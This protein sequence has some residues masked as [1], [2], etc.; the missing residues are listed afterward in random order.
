MNK[1]TTSLC[2]NP[3]LINNGKVENILFYNDS[4]I[5]AQTNRGWIGSNRIDVLEFNDLEFSKRNK[6]NLERKEH[7]FIKSPKQSSY[8][9]ST[10]YDIYIYIPST[11]MKLQPLGELEAIKTDTQI[12]F[13][14]FY[15]LT[16]TFNDG[17]SFSKDTHETRKFM[18][19]YYTRFELTDLGKQI[20]E[21]KELT[22]LD[23]IDCE[24]IVK[25]KAD[26][27]KVLAA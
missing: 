1:L 27:L 24:K 8:D 10:Q 23:T 11:S 15:E 26:L 25:H 12:H 13:G 7:F 14:K 19:G 21:I 4:G 6:L 5:I 2:Y 18:E 9:P 20:N 22:G 3:Y 16:A 17:Y